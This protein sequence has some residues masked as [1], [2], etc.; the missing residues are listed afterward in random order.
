[1]PAMMHC[2]HLTSSYVIPSDIKD[3]HNLAKMR[4][5]LV[6]ATTGRPH[7]LEQTVRHVLRQSWMPDLLVLSVADASDVIEGTLAEL[8]WPRIVITGTKGLCAQRNR[9]VQM[10]APGDILL[11]ID[12]DFLMAPDYIEQTLRL[13]RDNP[14]VV[15]ATGAVLA[16]GIL[17]PGLTFDAGIAVLRTA[18]PA[19]RVLSPAYNGY[20]CN[21]AMRALPILRDK[22]RFDESLPLYG[23]LEDVDFSRRLSA[24][25]RIVRSDAMRGVHLGTKI[26]RSS[27][28]ALGYSQIAN[29]VYLIRKGT[30]L[31]RRA[32]RLMVRNFSMNL[33]R[34]MRPEPWVDR[35]GRLR[36]NLLAL[37]DLCMGRLA[38]GRIVTLR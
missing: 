15:M 37:K 34:A 9:A 24:H 33:L 26:G 30:M 32:L 5:V 4:L 25:G 18:G 21:M 35:R 23:W 31:P 8:P 17:G 3:Q 27:G 28:V 11:M 16:D 38:P 12:D 36:G 2:E 7:I 10:A 22:I 19:R 14:D 1:M 6:I 13:F 29:P 20:G